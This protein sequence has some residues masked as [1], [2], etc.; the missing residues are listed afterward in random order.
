MN[1][2]FFRVF[3]LLGQGTQKQL[4]GRANDKPDLAGMAFVF[5]YTLVTS[6]HNGMH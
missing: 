5:A 4:Q 1:A 6:K 2:F 3:D